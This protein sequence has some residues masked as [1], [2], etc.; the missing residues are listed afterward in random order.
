MS[1]RTRNGVSGLLAKGAAQP[2]RN[3]GNCQ[4]FCDQPQHLDRQFPLLRALGSVYG[5][6]RA[7]DG[8]CEREQRYLRA[9][10]HC[11]SHQPRHPIPA[12]HIRA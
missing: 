10:S 8:L 6:V 5:S 7:A 2:L 11:A 9:S 12:D 1:L 4:F 3:C